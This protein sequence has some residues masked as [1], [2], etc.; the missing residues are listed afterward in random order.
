MAI[1]LTLFKNQDVLKVTIKILA[2]PFVLWT[3]LSCAEE[4]SSDVRGIDFLEGSLDE[5]LIVAQQQKLL[6]FVDFSIPNCAPCEVM[7]NEVYQ[8]PTLGEYMNTRFVSLMLDAENAEMDGPAL[9][10]KYE[11]GSYPTYLILDQDGELLNR[12][13][14]LMS[15][16]QFI[17]VMKRL[18]GETHSPLPAHEKRYAAGERDEQFIRS[19]LIDASI[20]LSLMPKDTANWKENMKAYQAAI[21]K[22]TSIAEQYLESKTPKDLLNAPDLAIIERFFHGRGDQWIEFVIS[23]FEAFLEIMGIAH[24]SRFV[25][26]ATSDATFILAMEGDESYN[27]FVD[28]LE[29]PPLSQVVEY[30]QQRDPDSVLLPDNMRVANT[31]TFEYWLEQRENEE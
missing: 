15:A 19:Y 20:E 27:A 30:E 21:D 12:A 9:A 22:Y 1:Q 2:L 6:V 11:V 4:P 31:R 24:M 14:S 18:M 28:M 16:E 29:E 26:T 7:H 5:A 17:N 13:T 3:S 8:D 10:N 25:L 23:H